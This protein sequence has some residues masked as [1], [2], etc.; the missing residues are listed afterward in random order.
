TLLELP[1]EDADVDL[2]TELLP[3]EVMDRAQRAGVAAYPTGITHGTVTLKLGALV[4]EVTTLRED[5]ETDGRH[6]VVTF[7]TS[8]RHDA[9]RR[10]FTLNALYA[11]MDGTL[12]DPLGGL[13]DC[14]GRKVRF[15]GRP[16][17]RI[18]EDRPRA[19]RSFRS[20]A[21]HGN[22]RVD[23]GGYTACHAAAG[24][25]GRLA[26]ERVGSEMR[27]MLRL[28]RVGNTLA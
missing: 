9:A 1:R 14:L 6:A 5:I 12:F 22:E 10:D 7:G 16:A 25:L 21:S 24:T 20:S 8:W 11:G 4:A 23:P 13:E 26:A 27:R 18:E 28:P 17:Q 2:A 19:Y 3:H 15:I